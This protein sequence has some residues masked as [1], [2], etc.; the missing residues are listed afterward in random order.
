MVTEMS[1][2]LQ[3]SHIA[4]D[5]RL[6]AVEALHQSRQRDVDGYTLRWCIECGQNW[7]CP[8]IDAVAGRRT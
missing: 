1:A 5:Y 8:T 3:G 2:T 7:P 6:A 4:A